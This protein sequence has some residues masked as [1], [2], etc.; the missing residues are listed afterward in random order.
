M[1]RRGIIQ[2]TEKIVFRKWQEHAWN[3]FVKNNYTGIIIAGTGSGKT[4]LGL[5]FIETISLNQTI[6]IIVPKI[7]L[8]YQWRDAILLNTHVKEV[9]LIGDGKNSPSRVTV[10]VIN[11][12]RDKTLVE[13]CGVK[14]DN[15]ILDEIHRYASEKNINILKSQTYNKVMGLTAT[16]GDI[17]FDDFELKVIFTYTQRQ[18]IQAGDLCEYDVWNMGV[19]LT[20]LERATYD[21]N[22]KQISATLKKYKIDAYT[23]YSNVGTP[24]QMRGR[25]ILRRLYMRRQDILYNA[26][27]KII[28]T[29]EL[30]EKHTNKKIIV[31]SK[32]IKT[33]TLLSKVLE[34]RGVKFGVY[35]SDLKDSVKQSV[36]YDYHINKTNI[37]LAVE[38]LD[39][40]LDVPSTDMCVII[41][42][43]KTERQSIQRVGRILRKKATVAVVIQLY[44]FD[45]KD[46]QWALTRLKY[47]KGKRQ[48]MW[49]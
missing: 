25:W 36:L 37:L 29:I 45:T 7:F 24:T 39:E 14:F 31:F 5:K 27:S 46:E 49:C 20:P 34:R 16:L 8:M 42:G 21:I 1:R 41:A 15:L 22:E 3:V 4:F 10:A 40:G 19:E 38:A 9:G 17:T 18:A 28:K 11:S 26:K 30:L 32:F 35:H 2:L 44:V 23:V 43:N 48:A 47:M 13:K 6:L 33:I 12:V